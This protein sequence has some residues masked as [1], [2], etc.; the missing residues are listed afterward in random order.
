MLLKLLGYQ[1]LYYKLYKDKVDDEVRIKELYLAYNEKL[2][3]YNNK[4]NKLKEC[5]EE[6][7]LR[8]RYAENNDEE[9]KRMKEVIRNTEKEVDLSKKILRVTYDVNDLER[10]RH[11][12]QDRN[13]MD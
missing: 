2:R 10:Y 5:L 8:W 3:S 6:V 1:T 7:N 13:G 11:K 12:K 9:N 4:M